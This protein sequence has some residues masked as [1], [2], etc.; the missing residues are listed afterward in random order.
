MLSQ[1]DYQHYGE[2][3]E[4]QVPHVLL[5]GGDRRRGVGPDQEEVIPTEPSSRLFATLGDFAGEGS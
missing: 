2:S 5:V 1:E 4:A 3:R